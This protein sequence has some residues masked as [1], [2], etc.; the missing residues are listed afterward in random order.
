MI[1]LT[2]SSPF[3]SVSVVLK[4][5]KGQQRQ[6][7]LTQPGKGAHNQIHI[8]I[9]QLLDD[10]DVGFLCGGHTR[11]T[12]ATGYACNRN[13]GEQEQRGVGVPL[14]YNK[15]KSENPLLPRLLRCCKARI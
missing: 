8:L 7:P 14:R 4:G 11:M 13:A 6:Y 12:K 10:V 15:D 1:A 3:I 5:G 2:T 9:L